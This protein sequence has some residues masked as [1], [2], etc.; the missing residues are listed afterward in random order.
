MR[1]ENRV[2]TR[3]GRGTATVHVF[4]PLQETLL[5]AWAGPRLGRCCG[6]V[7]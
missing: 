6:R 3:V 2:A 4:S 1:L 5:H 7:Q